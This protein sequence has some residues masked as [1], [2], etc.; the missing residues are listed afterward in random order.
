ME[1]Y[2]YTVY[3]RKLVGFK[4][5]HS[6]MRLV[7]ELTEFS[8]KKGGG[9]GRVVCAINEIASLNK[10]AVQAVMLAAISKAH[11]EKS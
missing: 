11:R 7:M 5:T 3:F 2:K 10:V 9:K 8:R 4:W 1:E 6:Y